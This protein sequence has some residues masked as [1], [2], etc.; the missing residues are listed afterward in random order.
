MTVAISMLR[1]V[2]WLD[3]AANTASESLGWVLD[4]RMMGNIDNPTVAMMQATPSLE[5]RKVSPARRALKPTA[6]SNGATMPIKG[7]MA[8]HGVARKFFT[9]AAESSATVLAKGLDGPF[10]TIGL[11]T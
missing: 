10:H 1:S 2:A 11:V 6:A 5:A 8:S 7:T 9:Q 3:E 4:G